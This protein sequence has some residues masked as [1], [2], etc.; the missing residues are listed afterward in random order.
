[1]SF[2][3]E[4]GIGGQ[5][6]MVLSEEKQDVAG[7]A[8]LDLLC[9]PSTSGPKSDKLP[10]EITNFTLST[11]IIALLR[12]FGIW[13]VRASL[14]NG[15]FGREVDPEWLD[16]IDK[17]RWTLLPTWTCGDILLHDFL[18][19]DA[20]QHMA[21]L[22][23]QSTD[24]L[25]FNIDDENK[26]C[27]SYKEWFWMLQRLAQSSY[28]KTYPS[29]KR[30]MHICRCSAEKKANEPVEVEEPSLSGTDRENLPKPILS[31][32]NNKKLFRK[33][34]EVKVEEVIIS[35][36][37][38]EESCEADYDGEDSS[39]SS[40]L[41]LMKAPKKK[42]KR[43]QKSHN[44]SRSG[45]RKEIV[46]PAPFVM[47]G[48]QTLKSFLESFDV[49]FG[50]KFDGNELEKTQQLSKFLS[51]QLKKVYDLKGGN[52]V[53]Y[54]EMRRE[55]LDY[56]KEMKIGSKKF[57]KNQLKTLT[58]EADEEYNILSRR[59]LA[60]AKRAYPESSSECAHKLR[61]RFLEIIPPKVAE[62]V[63]ETERVLKPVRKRKHFTFEELVKQTATLD[64]GDSSRH[65]MWTT[66]VPTSK[67]SGGN[68]S[69][70][71][72]NASGDLTKEI[73]AHREKCSYCKL[74]RRDISQ[75]WRWTKMC[76]LCG[77]N[78]KMEDCSKYDPNFKSSY[79]ARRNNE[80]K[81]LN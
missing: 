23:T 43:K 74:G 62:K 1:M 64:T 45:E 51:G 70:Y 67:N 37:S 9:D 10:S 4:K 29:S 52:T 39:S 47:D 41:E 8:P 27:T 80:T 28:W 15:K 63:L 3:G 46:T 6:R 58:R 44:T 78:H 49:Y 35:S 68:D 30:C 20:A 25:K 38:D 11:R 48:N 79:R 2:T 54:K 65:I 13:E 72:V 59:M 36:S 66:D 31:N 75:C 76:L 26:E 71:R 17:L 55:L 61:E 77:R 56:Y 60:M 12:Q 16:L 57:F 40:C 19:S 5:G 22:V 14:V 32:V 53:P 81:P 21:K 69:G 34:S 50:K 18:A 73:N 24:L 7:P 33:T 42:L